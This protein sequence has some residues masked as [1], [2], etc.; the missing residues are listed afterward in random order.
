[1][2]A[3]MRPTSPL[4]YIQRSPCRWLPSLPLLR[5]GVALATQVVRLQCRERQLTFSAAARPAWRLTPVSGQVRSSASTPLGAERADPSVAIGIAGWRPVGTIAL[6]KC[7]RRVGGA[8]RPSRTVEFGRIQESGAVGSD[9]RFHVNSAAGDRARSLLLGAGG[10][11]AGVRA[12][13]CSGSFGQVRAS[14]RP[15]RQRLLLGLAQRRSGSIPGRARSGCLLALTSETPGGS[16]GVTLATRPMVLARSRSG[17]G[18]D[19]VQ[20]A[21]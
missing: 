13:V 10:H 9:V 15:A 17:F 2:Q 12:G 20:E 11:R 1:L 5:S 4:S 19:P 21:L 3:G 8:V 16:S 18:R 14:G 7:D 6:R